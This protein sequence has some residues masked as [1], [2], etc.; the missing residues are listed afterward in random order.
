MAARKRARARQRQKL[1]HHGRARAGPKPAHSGLDRRFEHFVEEIAVHHRRVRERRRAARD[2]WYGTFGPAGPF[3]GALMGM[4]C[5]A[6]LAWAISIANTQ[7]NAAFLSMLS[8]FLLGNL[9]VFLLIF[10]SVNY[11]KHVY[12]SHDR[13]YHI[14]KPVKVAVEAAVAL[15]LLGWVMYFGGI[16]TGSILLAEGGSL[17]LRSLGGLF[18]LIL[19]V[20]YM[21]AMVRRS[22]EA[23]AGK[24]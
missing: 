17:V 22:R 12:L 4:V 1:G 16:Q 6:I 14:F 18:T 5:V 23:Y 19:I 11:L 9:T 20:G 8:S 21:L 7:L 24:R 10:L 3:L 13:L 2:W 15:W